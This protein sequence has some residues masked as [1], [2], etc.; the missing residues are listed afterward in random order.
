MKTAKSTRYGISDD[1][2]PCGDCFT[3][4]STSLPTDDSVVAAAGVDGK[5]MTTSAVAADQTNVWDRAGID[6]CLFHDWRLRWRSESLMRFRDCDRLLDTPGRDDHW[7]DVATPQPTRQSS[8][9]LSGRVARS[10]HSST[11]L[12]RAAVLMQYSADR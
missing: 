6:G 1:F 11:V 5:K 12:P 2:F 7:I 9:W 8:Q 4:I 3:A 10:F